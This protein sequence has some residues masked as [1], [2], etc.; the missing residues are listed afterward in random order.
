MLCCNGRLQWYG[1][2]IKQWYDLPV[3]R[4][5]STLSHA[6]LQQLALS[7]AYYPVAGPAQYSTY[8][9]AGDA[10]PPAS[11]VVMNYGAASDPSTAASAQ[12]PVADAGKQQSQAASATYTTPLG[13]FHPCSM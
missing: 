12:S 3:K 1:V 4:D 10:P 11:S 5:T 9:S 6:E 7:S 8:P 13:T 2:P